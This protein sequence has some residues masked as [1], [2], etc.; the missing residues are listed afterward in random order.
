M[1][2]VLHRKRRPC[3]H[4]NGGGPAVARYGEVPT[5]RAEIGA[6]K[7]QPGGEIIAWVGADFARALTRAG[8]VDPH[9]II[10]QPVAYGGGEPMSQDPPDALHLNLV[11]ATTFSTGTMLHL[12]EPRGWGAQ[13]GS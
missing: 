9:S 13:A 10:H 6:L 11:A 5:Y 3:G 4:P 1:A 8:L 7:E 12:Y 2:R